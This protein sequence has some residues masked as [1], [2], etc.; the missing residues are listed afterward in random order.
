MLSLS[1]EFKNIISFSFHGET[2]I[3]SASK[4]GGTSIVW[5]K[6]EE[7]VDIEMLIEISERRSKG[8]KYIKTFLII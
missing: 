7:N 4:Y 5:I 8:R 3:L 6:N 1:K 2:L